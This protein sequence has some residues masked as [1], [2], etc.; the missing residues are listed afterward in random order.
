MEVGRGKGGAVVGHGV[1]D[2]DLM[3]ERRWAMTRVVRPI[4][5]RSRASCKKGWDGEEEDKAR[6]TSQMGRSGSIVT[7]AKQASEYASEQEGEGGGQRKQRKR[8]EGR[9]AGES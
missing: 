6:Q 2:E 9:R 1:G 4:M 5:M 3:V 8:S 7:S